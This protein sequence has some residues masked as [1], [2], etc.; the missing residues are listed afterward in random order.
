MI[1]LIR[2]LPARTI[3][4]N[5][6]PLLGEPER[7]SV[8]AIEGRMMMQYRCN[9]IIEGTLHLKR[10]YQKNMLAALAVGISL[11]LAALGAYYVATGSYAP[12][13]DLGSI[14]RIGQIVIELPQ[15]PSVVPDIPMADIRVQP[16]ALPDFF[17]PEPVDDWLVP[18]RVVLPTNMEK[19]IAAHTGGIGDAT[20]SVGAA[21]VPP[22]VDIDIP[23][24]NEFR[25]AQEYP[26]AVDLAKAVYPEMARK[27]GLQCTVIVRV[28]IDIS[29]D[30]IDARVVKASAEGMGFEEAALE[31]AFKSKWTPAFQN[32]QP[33]PFW[34]SYTIEFVLE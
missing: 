9:P 13:A 30:V 29:G 11:H 16:G 26:K 24:I 23:G 27:A 28:L 20:G 34:Q 5:R 31:A 10:S 7:L 17:I 3:G 12:P 18:D 15:P 21:Y 19:Y 25:C 6:L 2:L 1:R 22:T 4:E 33:V 14:P 8:E 32:N